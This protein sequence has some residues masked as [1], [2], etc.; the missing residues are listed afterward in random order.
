MQTTSTVFF[1]QFC[2]VEAATCKY[3]EHTV[4][5][6]AG[7]LTCLRCHTCPDGF[8]LFPQCSTRIKDSEIKN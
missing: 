6:E 4:E 3:S 1:F 8:G 7:K 2:Q 5:S